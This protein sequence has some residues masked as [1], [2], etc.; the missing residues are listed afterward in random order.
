ME[1][2]QEIQGWRQSATP[3][4]LWQYQPGQG[5]NLLDTDGARGE[6]RP[7]VV[8][9]ALTGQCFKEC[10]FCYASATATGAS[11]W[12]YEELVGLVTDL[13]R[14]GA[15]SVA[16]GGG[17]PLLWRDRRQGKTFYDLLEDLASRVSLD[18]T[19]TTSGEPEPQV[20]RLAN[21]PVRVS[22]HL[23]QELPRVLRQ[24][25]RLRAKVSRVG[26]NLLLWPDQ[27]EQC[28]GAVHTLKAAGVEDILLLTIQA[29]GRGANFGHALL[30]GEKLAQ[31]IRSLGQG[32]FRLT[33]CH[34]PPSRAI[35]ADLG[36]GA[37]DWFVSIDQNKVVRACSFADAG[38]PLAEAT[39]QALLQAASDPARP[40][41]Y[42]SVWDS[43][44]GSFFNCK[45]FGALIPSS[46][47]S[48]E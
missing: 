22:C 40:R 46:Q 32:T 47:S 3:V 15:H 2:T 25:E 35:G 30:D 39:Y 31:F 34:A 13:D 21:V 12:S 45:R 38:R 37:G 18:L 27:L 43:A 19:W 8:S 29:V 28:R 36:C 24:V 11:G 7:L 44:I 17:E 1:R 14:N 5:L 42:R 23:V 41:C 9:I 26:V 10:E 16:L 6:W 33:A 4:G 20:H 48:L